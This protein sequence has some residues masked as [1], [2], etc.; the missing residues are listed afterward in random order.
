[1]KLG[2]LPIATKKSIDSE[3]LL[4]L[5][6]LLFILYYILSSN[7]NSIYL[8]FLCYEIIGEIGYAIWIQGLYYLLLFEKDLRV[9]FHQ[10]TA[11]AYINFAF[12]AV[13]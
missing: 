10:E 1:M 7:V 4:W 13:G 9:I 8:L 3:S 5:I 2:T 6:L 11:Y 12:S